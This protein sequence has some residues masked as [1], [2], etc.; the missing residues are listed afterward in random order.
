MHDFH[1]HSSYS[2]DCKYCMETMVKGAI[3]ANVKSIVFTDHI[4]YEYGS[5][6]INFVFEIKDYLKD[7]MKLRNKYGNDVQILSGLEIGMQPYLNEKNN[8]LV[9]SH[10]FDFIIMSTHLVEGVE[11]HGGD[12]FKNKKK[13]DVFEKYYNEVLLNLNSFSNFDVVGHLNLI[14]R[15][16]NFKSNDPL[17]I[18]DY[19]D[20][21]KKVLEKIISMGKGIEI[22]TSGYRYGINSCLPNIEIIKLY[23]ELGGE[24]FTIGS[25]AH[26]P[27][28]IGH[29]FDFT[30]ALLKELGYTHMSMFKNRRNNF[31]KID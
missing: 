13:I 11:I 2:G 17:N 22:N 18:G 3:K 9:Q 5:P 8:K 14:D 1:V 16:I 15:Y 27:S 29:N 7:I 6:D 31:I 20:I 19:R 21:L 28:D 30:K 24:I 25:D 10:E 4:D 12:F 26:T 23:K